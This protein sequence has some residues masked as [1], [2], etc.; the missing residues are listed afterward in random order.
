MT[1][2]FLLCFPGSSDSK[3]S[4]CNAGYLGLITGLGRSPGRGDGNPLKYS[5]LEDPHGERSMV[6][7]SPWGRKE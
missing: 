4:T 5:C 7:Y 6:G 2:Q 1:E 3:E